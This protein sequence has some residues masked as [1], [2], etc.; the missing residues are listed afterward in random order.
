MKKYYFLAFI[1]VSFI[2]C[3]NSEFRKIDLNGTEQ[4]VFKGDYFKTEKGKRLN[5]EGVEFG[6]EGYTE[7]ANELLLKADKIEPNNATILNNIGITYS[8]LNNYNKAIEYYLKSIK[9]SDSTYLNAGNNLSLNYFRTGEFEKGVEIANFVITKSN[10]KLQT[11]MARIHKS[12]NLTA[13][14]KC[15]K[16]KVELKK[17]EKLMAENSGLQNQVDLIKSKI[18]NCVQ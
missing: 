5:N 18:K 7:K 17:I 1:F 12:F 15:E 6:K 10:N 2:S 3:K 8:H 16:A 14:G 4:I 9:V 11:A 13:L